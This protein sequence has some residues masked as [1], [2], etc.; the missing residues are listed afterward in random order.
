[1][2]KLYNPLGKQ[3]GSK[4]E[5]KPELHEA[6]QWAAFARDPQQSAFETFQPDVKPYHVSKDMEMLSLLFPE[7]SHDVITKAC[8]HVSSFQTAVEVR[9][10][11]RSGG[12][13]HGGGGGG[14]GDGT[15]GIRLKRALGL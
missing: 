6:Q 4:S 9:H 10:A 12:P 3:G 11:C 8:G 2:E 5:V 14:G 15:A 13:L 1:M 7:F